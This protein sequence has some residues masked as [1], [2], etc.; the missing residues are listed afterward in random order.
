MSPAPPKRTTIYCPAPPDLYIALDALRRVKQC[1]TGKRVSL[2]EIVLELLQ[3]HPDVQD[4][5]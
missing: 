1:D 4:A 5:S 2:A 3:T